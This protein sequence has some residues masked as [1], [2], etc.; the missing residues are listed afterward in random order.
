MGRWLI[1]R[2]FATRLREQQI[3]LS[4]KVGQNEKNNEGYAG[5][6]RPFALNPALW[7]A[8]EPSPGLQIAVA[9]R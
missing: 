6:F 1:G 9:R 3:V 4:C 5:Y 7:Q 2:E 8:C